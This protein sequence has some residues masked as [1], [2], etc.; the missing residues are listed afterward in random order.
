[1]Q[2]KPGYKQTEVGIIPS[3]W[4]LI[5]YNE[6]FDFLRTATYSHA[7]LSKNDKTKYIHY[8][9]IHT[10]CKHFLDCSEIELPSI[11]N[12]QLKNYPPIKDGDIIVVDASEDY[13]GVGKSVEV[14]NTGNH[15]VIAGLHTFLLRDANEIIAN[16]FKG[17]IWSNKLVKK[18]MDTLATG[19]KVYGVSKTNLRLIKIPLPPTK[20]EQT[21]IAT[22]L[23]DAD[24][25]ISALEKLIA[26]KRLIKQGAMQELLRPKEGWEVK[27]LGEIADVVGGG[28]PSTFIEKYWNGN[29]NWYTPTEVGNNKYSYQS[30]RKISQEGLINSS[31]KLLPIGTILLTSRASIGEVSI[32]KTEACTNQGFQS[33]IVKAGNSN[34]FLYYLLLTMTQLLIQ[35]ASGSTFLEI[36][37]NR[38]KSIEV[39]IPEYK[40]Q[41][42]IAQI[43][44]D[45]DTEIEALEKKLE[46]YKRIKQ[47]MM[48][49]LLTGKKR[50]V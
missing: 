11:K 24:A 41:M 34:E 3:D 50:L 47:G 30:R 10:K 9:D 29:I 42:F 22:A 26:K 20:A 33:L 8:G 5:S 40:S 18:Q 39:I 21:A 37:P 12:E 27:R 1:M 28:T 43:L 4:E 46:K 14:R 15:K 45:M 23:S 6:A 49:E 35:Y 32:L 36:S 44:S 48:E 19:L 13:K 2:V 7:Q 31:A 17:Y 25:L 16:G 38:I